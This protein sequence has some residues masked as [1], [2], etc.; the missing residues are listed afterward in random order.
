MPWMIGGVLLAVWVGKDLPEAIFKQGMA[1]V[2]LLSVL[3][4]YWWDKQ[5]EVKVPENRI[6]GW[7]MGL[8]VGFT[9]MIG[10]L[11]GPFANIFFLAMRLPKKNSSVLPLGYFLLLTFLNSHFTFLFGVPLHQKPWL[12]I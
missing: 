1:I 6:F 7:F 12:L 3:I 2:I 4:M 10:N 5:E 8:V 11:A 9:T